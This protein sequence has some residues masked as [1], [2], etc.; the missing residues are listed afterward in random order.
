MAWL[1]AFIVEVLLGD[2]V[3]DV[4]LW[5]CRLLRNRAQTSCKQEVGTIGTLRLHFSAGQISFIMMRAQAARVLALPASL[6]I[7]LTWLSV[8]VLVVPGT[9]SVVL[10][11]S[12]LNLIV[13]SIVAAGVGG[14]VL[15]RNRIC[16]SVII[17]QIDHY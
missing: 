15:V 14:N 17:N 4:G 1:E 7:G 5:P 11:G 12:F 10:D 9:I 3:D 2:T 16:K 13:L 6:L 8:H